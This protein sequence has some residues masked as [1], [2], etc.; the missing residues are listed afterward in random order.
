[1]K[2]TRR[3]SAHAIAWLALVT[4][5]ATAAADAAPVDLALYA[6]LLERHTRSVDDVAGTRVD[7]A[8]LR[9]DPAWRA[10]L[11]SLAAAPEPPASDRDARL[12]YWINA[13]NI[14]AIDV[15]VA[16]WPVAS[17]RDVGSL[18]RPVW[19]I[20]AGTASGRVL[21]L[22]AIEHGILR[23]M[24]E[25]RIHLAIVCAST[26]CPS[27]A[28]EP[29]RAER[30]DAQ[31]DA[32]ARGFVANPEKGVRADAH[33]LRLSKIFD[34]FGEDFAASGGVLA[35][36]RGHA[37]PELRAAIDALGPDP[38]LDWFDYDWALNGI[39]RPPR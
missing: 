15:V 29:Y 31:L 21:S 30:L 10:L 18:L 5:A 9:G 16:H 34:W 22:D 23:P 26:S 17:I 37:A 32:A 12:A 2:R 19:K 28:R 4:A 27:L 25:P 1:M 14:L 35:F 33:A 11:A 6:R 38:A 39:G 8:A 24:G 20:D 36:V 7:Y 3:A 13:Y